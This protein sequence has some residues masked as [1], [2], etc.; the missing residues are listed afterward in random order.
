MAIARRP[1]RDRSDIASTAAVDAF[2]HGAERGQP[3]AEPPTKAKK[4]KEPIILRFD[5]AV[6]D[7]I[8]KEAGKLG[9]SRAAW[10]RMIV[11][12]ALPGGT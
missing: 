2:I 5:E 7:A 3:P 1:N 12:Q 6:I 11:A 8:D 10:V 9:L 4:K